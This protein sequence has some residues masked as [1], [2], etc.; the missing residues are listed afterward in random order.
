MAGKLW[1]T[2]YEKGFFCA[3]DCDSQGRRVSNQRRDS[4]RYFAFLSKESAG[5]ESLMEEDLERALVEVVEFWKASPH[6]IS[7]WRHDARIKRGSTHQEQSYK[8]NIR[9]KK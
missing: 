4:R 8:N 3:G 5:E 9:E 1:R 2:H 7:G 6:V